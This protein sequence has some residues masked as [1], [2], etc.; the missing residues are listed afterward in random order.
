[1]QEAVLEFVSLIEPF[2]SKQAYELSMQTIEHLLAAL[3]TT[4]VHQNERQ[5]HKLDQ[6]VDKY[7]SIRVRLSFAFIV[8]WKNVLAMQDWASVVD[9]RNLHINW[10]VPR[11][12]HVAMA[13]KVLEGWLLK[14]LKLLDT[15]GMMT[16]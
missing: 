14:Q 6:P 8:R 7:L 11:A 10:H 2:E 16:K 4:Y 5:R 15:P 13:G 12:E 9:R 1:M 3:C